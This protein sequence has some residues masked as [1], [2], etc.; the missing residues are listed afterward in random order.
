[1]AA[2]LQARHVRPSLSRLGEIRLSSYGV[3]SSL[4]ALALLALLPLDTIRSMDTLATLILY[5]AATALAYTSATVVTGL[6][7]AAAGCCDEGVEALKR[8]RALGGFRSRVREL[9]LGSVVELIG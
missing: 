1:M 3:L 4:I 8:G 9:S 2:L 6:T 7:A 5:G